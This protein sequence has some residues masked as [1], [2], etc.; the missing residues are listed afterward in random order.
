M[1]SHSP[2]LLYSLFTVFSPLSLRSFFFPV[3]L[4][5]PT[6][7]RWFLTIHGGTRRSSLVTRVNPDELGYDGS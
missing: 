7:A 2:Q 1:D 4:A 5:V 3:F 6:F